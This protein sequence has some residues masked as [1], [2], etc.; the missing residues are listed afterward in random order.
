MKLPS[1]SY[2]GCGYQ[3]AKKLAAEVWLEGPGAADGGVVT[4]QQVPLVCVAWPVTPGPEL[5][6]RSHSTRPNL[7]TQASGGQKGLPIY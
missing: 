4:L 5:F 3:P 6:E 2:H 7:P 1:W